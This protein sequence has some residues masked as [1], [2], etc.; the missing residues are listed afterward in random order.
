MIS[1]YIWY[2]VIFWCIQCHLI[3]FQLYSTYNCVR[4]IHVA[5]PSVTLTEYLVFFTLKCVQWVDWKKQTK[6]TCSLKK[7]WPVLYST[8]IW[9][10]IKIIHT[11]LFD[12]SYWCRHKLSLRGAGKSSVCLIH[13]QV[14]GQ[15]CY[16]CVKI[17][18]VETPLKSIYIV[19]FK[20]S[21]RVLPWVSEEWKTVNKWA[22]KQILVNLKDTDLCSVA[23]DEWSIYCLPF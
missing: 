6:N 9:C 4:I 14:G 23:M 15:L 19:I 11:W 17:Y 3:S 21:H 13:T 18:Y 7:T 12:S 10:N 22:V 1:W 5:E 2:N 16:R 20:H 8:F